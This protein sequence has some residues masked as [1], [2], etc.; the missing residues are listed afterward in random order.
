MLNVPDA[1][2]LCGGAGSRL[3]AVTDAPKGMAKVGSRPFLELLLRQVRRQ[4]IARCIM[5]VGYGSNLIQ[6]HFGDR[7]FGLE[8]H[9]SNED[10]PLGTG[11]A[12]RKAAGLVI[13]EMALVMNGDSYTN[14]DLRELVAKHCEAKADVSVLVVAAGNRS[15]CG[16]VKLGRE[17]RIIA[18]QEKQDDAG[19]PYMNAG[20]YVISRKMLYNIPSGAPISLERA[21]FPRWLEEQRHIQAV[22]APVP[23]IDIGTPERYRDAQQSLAH[24]EEENFTFESL[25]TGN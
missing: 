12:L 16:Q 11:G 23:C 18:F 8:L 7:A 3:R 1:I 2:I 25:N 9:Y 15:D 6:S 21:V 17:N 4:G 19:L 10:T 13:S 20:T 14:A 22:H 24:V 5:A